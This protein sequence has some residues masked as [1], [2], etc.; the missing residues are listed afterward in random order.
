MED[1]GREMEDWGQ[2]ILT[3]GGN[4]FSRCSGCLAMSD[5]LST[6]FFMS[7]YPV[8]TVEV[9]VRRLGSLWAGG[10]VVRGGWL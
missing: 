4:S 7:L 10:R 9:R 8:C 2:K 1:W 3:L 5:S 6:I